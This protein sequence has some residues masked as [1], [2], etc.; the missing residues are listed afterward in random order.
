M[1]GMMI[2][3]L[4]KLID[5]YFI[6]QLG[7][8]A[9]AAFT[10]TIPVQVLI[11]SLASAT[12]VGVT[13]LIARKLGS[14]DVKYADNIA[15]H[16]III[17]IGYGLF[18]LT[19]GT[20][21][22]DDLLIFFGCTPETFILS[23]NYLNIILWGCV[24]AFVPMIMESCIQGE[25]N[26][27]LP[28]IISLFTMAL[29]VC[30]DPLFILGWG[31]IKGMGL[32]GAAIAT[33]IA[34]FFGFILLVV[35]VLKK[36]YILTWSW[37]HFRPSWDVV[38][39]IYMVGLPT[40]IMELMGVFIMVFL[41]RLLAAYS[42]TAVAA[43]GILLRVRSLLLMPAA[44][45]SQGTMP[46]AAYAYGAGNLDRVKETIIKASV[47]TF[48]MMGAGWFVIQS[49]PVWILEFFSDDPALTVLGVA[50]LK[51][52]TFF[53]PLMG[54]LVILNTVLQALGKGT[55]AMWF[56]VFR[57]MGIFFPLLLILPRSI[58]LNGIWLAFALSEL[59]W[60][61]M[62]LFVYS[63]LWKELQIRK[64]S[65]LFVFFKIGYVWQR[66][67]AWLKW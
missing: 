33:I 18:F 26:I 29:E 7:P 15:W 63:G 51:M 34:Q 4:L 23:K 58:N 6:A 45:L 20:S 54:P 62:V 8:V 66:V 36:R 31:P 11:T 24:L 5:T 9:L 22:I 40:M 53:L 44:G 27:I 2:F 59:L 65:S 16:G 48:L 25:G 60:G 32:N 49:Y 19:I 38:K 14:G 52:A 57:H 43:L 56:S 35:M 50:C 17:S 47:L 41:N 21:F 61:M 12:G 39:G 30:F 1:T 28:M 46:I 42:Y 64:Q 10:L 13:S 37:T 55:R 67:L 3:S